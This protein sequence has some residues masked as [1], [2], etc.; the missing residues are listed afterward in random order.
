MFL[1]LMKKTLYVI[2][3]LNLLSCN[4]EEKLDLPIEDY[5]NEIKALSSK[6]YYLCNF[7]K[8]SFILRIKR[9]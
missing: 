5:K 9:R 3:L 6:D 7:N 4:S 1:K 8:I 2:I